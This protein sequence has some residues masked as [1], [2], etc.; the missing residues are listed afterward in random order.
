M[1][2]NSLSRAFIR[3]F[4]R[5]AYVNILDEVT[6]G[7]DT[8]EVAR[9]QNDRQSPYKFTEIGGF[10]I[11]VGRVHLVIAELKA[12]GAEGEKV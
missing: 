9:H 6:K 3:F 10:R 12:Y 5:Y 1:V 8:L 11:R 2:F 4:T 7:K